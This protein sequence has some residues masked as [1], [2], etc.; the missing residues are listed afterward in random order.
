M[1]FVKKPCRLGFEQFIKNPQNKLRL[2]YILAHFSVR[3]VL[4]KTLAFSIVRL[5]LILFQTFSAGLEKIAPVD[6]VGHSTGILCLEF[7]KSG[8]LLKKPLRKYTLTLFLLK[9]TDL[10]SEL[11]VLN[12][13][14]FNLN[15]T[16]KVRLVFQRFQLAENNYLSRILTLPPCADTNKFQPQAVL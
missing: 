14:P 15:P 12:F 4:L 6:P 3:I 1:S 8:L 16:K 11:R 13:S 9:N 10:K 5:A 2:L 7:K